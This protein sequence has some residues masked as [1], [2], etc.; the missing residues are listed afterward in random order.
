[1]MFVQ[2][3]L[4]AETCNTVCA[5]KLFTV[6]PEFQY[7]KGTVLSID[8]TT[9]YFHFTCMFLIPDPFS[10]WF[11]VTCADFT[12]FCLATLHSYNHCCLFLFGDFPIQSTSDVS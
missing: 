2:W 5:L 10:G 7:N 6:C 12:R 3:L 1:M 8:I 4:A 9:A 11:L